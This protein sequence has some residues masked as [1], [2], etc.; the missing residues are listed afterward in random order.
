M[1]APWS[2]RHCYAPLQGFRCALQLPPTRHV[3]HTMRRSQR[4][5]RL[6]AMATDEKEA[7]G[8]EE[9]EPKSRWSF[10]FPSAYTILFA[11]LLIVTALTWIIPAGR[12]RLDA[13]GKPVP[14]TYHQVPRNPQQIVPD[15]LLAPID[16]M[17]GLQDLATGHISVDNAGVLYGS[18]NI[19]LFVLVIGGFLGITMKTG[20]I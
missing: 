15:T 1:P 11:I 7:S 3:Q 20:A 2:R 9:N 19:A 12:Y 8:I 5:R 16:G 4:H 17:Y 14:G 18:I 10:T 13:E 6:S